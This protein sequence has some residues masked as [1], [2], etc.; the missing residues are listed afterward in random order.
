MLKQSVLI[1]SFQI[2]AHFFIIWMER[3]WY[4]IVQA[5]V[6]TTTVPAGKMILFL[7]KRKCSRVAVWY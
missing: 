6:V 3:A 5:G 2:L 1:T 7:Q 4:M